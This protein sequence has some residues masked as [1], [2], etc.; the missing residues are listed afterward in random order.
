MKTTHFCVLLALAAMLLTSTAG[1]AVYFQDNFDSYA[2]E[3]AFTAA[4]WISTNTVGAAPAP[5]PAGPGTYEIPGPVGTYPAQLGTGNWICL[6][7]FY[8]YQKLVT[9]GPPPV[10]TT[11]YSYNAQANPPARNGLPTT[12]NQVT[13]NSDWA[14]LADIPDSGASH[15][16]YSPTFATGDTPYLHT[17]INFIA[18]NNN[19]KAVAMIDAS[20]DGGATWN[21]VW[22]R[23]SV[24]R[25]KAAGGGETGGGICTTYLEDHTN[26]GGYYGVLDLNLASVAN[27]A[28]VQLRFRHYEPNDDW[29]FM[30]DD[31]VVDDNAGPQKGPY[32]VF[33]AD[34][35]ETV[36]TG[37]PL[38]S[39]DGMT[40]EGA[41][42]NDPGAQYVFGALQNDKIN[43]INWNPADLNDKH[44]CAAVTQGTTTGTW[45]MTPVLD[46]SDLTKVMLA[47]DDEAKAVNNTTGLQEVLVMQDTDL[48]GVAESTDTV[49]G[50]VF[51]YQTAAWQRGNEDANYQNRVFEVAE[52]AG[53]SNVFFAFHNN[54]A[55]T[56][57][58]YFWAV[59]NVSVTGVPEPSTIALLIGAALMGLVAYRRRG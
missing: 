42:D 30:I 2:T 47:Y 51:K 57:Q 9:I 21:T 29:A 58:K 14:P 12:G 39:M 8:S 36:T 52:A 10:Y 17:S 48:D 43:R 34:F 3:A 59:D 44:F 46:C 20:T 5:L 50:T 33:S 27:Q 26:A 6:D 28:A 38:P 37:H 4:G 7:T 56:D 35:A 55:S 16:L 40:V 22:Q 54:S 1:A 24:G 49:L 18:N 19:G 53:L 15:D 45:M 23:S 32:S 25:S 13:A 31:V 11:V 41:W